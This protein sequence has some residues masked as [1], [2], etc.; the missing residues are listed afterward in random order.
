MVGSASKPHRYQPRQVTFQAYLTSRFLSGWPSAI[1]VK[2]ERAST[3]DVSGR[4]QV[5]VS[6]LL[7]PSSGFCL[8][9]MRKNKG[10]ASPLARRWGLFNDET[11]VGA[12]FLVLP[13]SKRGFERGSEFNDSGCWYVVSCCHSTGITSAEAGSSQSLVY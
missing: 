11:L 6:C 2:L 4:W 7:R 12:A 13:R 3:G 10:R 8:S 9:V 5:D 1:W